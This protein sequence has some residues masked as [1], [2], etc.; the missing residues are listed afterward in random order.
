MISFCFF[1]L[2]YHG[3]ILFLVLRSY[4]GDVLPLTNVQR[5]DM[6]AYLCIA[7]NG[8]PPT[9]SRRFNVVVHCKYP[10]LNLKKRQSLI[11]DLLVLSYRRIVRDENFSFIA[12]KI[13]TSK[14]LFIFNLCVWVK[15]WQEYDC[16]KFIEFISFS[17]MVWSI[18]N[19]IPSLSNV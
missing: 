8:I 9:V 4:D 16:L 7:S 5:T 12:F 15:I 10:T 1:V 2:F 3:F 18:H 14:S 11:Y 17:V 19:T 6:G 13:C